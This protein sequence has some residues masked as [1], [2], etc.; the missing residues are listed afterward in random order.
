MIGIK[1]SFIFGLLCTVVA[2]MV[3]FPA[4]G[5]KTRSQ[6]KYDVFLLIGQSNMAGRGSMIEGD[7]EVFDDNVFLLNE[8]GEIEPASNPL[9]KYSTIRKD[10]KMQQIGPGFSFSR[11][12][13]QKTGRKILL[14]VNARGGSNLN[15]WK[16]GAEKGY[17]DEAVKRTRQAL[18][19]D[20]ELK[21]ILWHQGES[22]CS[23]TDY[24]PELAK[25]V[26]SLRQDLGCGD[27]PFIA[28]EL[29]YWRKSYLE[30]NSRICRISEYITNSDFVSA[31]GCMMLIDE[32]DP[33]FSRDGQILLGERYADK[34]L[35]MCYPA[36]GA[37]NYSYHTY[38]SAQ[39]DTLPYRS[40]SPAE[41]KPGRKYPLILLLHDAG[42]KGSDNERQLMTGAKMFLNPV[43][44]EEFPAFVLIPQCKAGEWWTYDRKP[45][46][47]DGLPYAD[48]L[49]TYLA[50]V[51]T[52]LDQYLAMPEVDKSRIYVMGASMGGVGTFDIVSH[53][54]EI[55]A[56]AVPICGAIA[57]GHLSQAKDVNFWIF[58]GD[59]D[60]TV[61][62]Y[63][64]RRAYMELKA[65]GADVRYTEYP[66]GKHNINSNV[67]NT[68]GFMKWL[69]SQKRK[70]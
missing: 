22:N 57:P 15:D 40:L 51:K 5:K 37:E 35:R 34:V 50:M 1:R 23:D 65:A 19:H 27:V 18:E 69:F 4:E 30:F 56:A 58:H 67:Y 66:G 9:N 53:Y 21:A 6:D 42:K 49:N 54:P 70:K 13:S 48:T 60:Q 41:M 8:K 36:P 46:D 44:R 10:M 31:K 43:N 17:Y 47:F 52:V 2:F 20:A 7:S 11:K 59:D 26:T 28:G 12:I 62:V 45:K 61:P 55:F 39:G 14:V 3:S 38:I 68:P 32:K 64:S 24:L 63:C 29:A 33:H 16:V 25:V